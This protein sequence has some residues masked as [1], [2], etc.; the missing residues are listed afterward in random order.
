MYT[1]GKDL[2]IETCVLSQRG[3]NSAKFDS[4]PSFPL[5]YVVAEL[6]P[7][8]RRL[9]FGSLCDIFPALCEPS[10]LQI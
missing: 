6:Q 10:L 5:F 1:A 3:H 2:D 7:A 4:D 9:C 8:L